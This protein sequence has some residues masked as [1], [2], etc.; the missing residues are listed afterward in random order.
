MITMTCLLVTCF[1]DRLSRT[2][3]VAPVWMWVSWQV[4]SKDTQF[5][6]VTWASGQKARKGRRHPN[7]QV[8]SVSVH[9]NGWSNRFFWEWTLARE[10]A[11]LAVGTLLSGKALHVSL[12]SSHIASLSLL[13][14]VQDWTGVSGSDQ[15]RDSRVP[16]FSHQL[17]SP[18]YALTP[19]PLLLFVLSRFSS[20]DSDFSSTLDS[21]CFRVTPLRSHLFRHQGIGSWSERCRTNGLYRRWSPDDRCFPSSPL[22]ISSQFDVW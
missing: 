7:A 4:I 2:V 14:A 15:E 3:F 9:K 11:S 12:N 18:P 6:G 20:G 19:M 10:R 21:F 16:S 5:G 13:E 22:L 8:S 17:C 1:F